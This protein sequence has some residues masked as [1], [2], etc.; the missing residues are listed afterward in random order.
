MISHC[1]GPFKAVGSLHS[2]LNQ[3][4][5]TRQDHQQDLQGSWRGNE[6]MSIP[7]TDGFTSRLINFLILLGWVVTT[8][9]HWAMR[10]RH[11]KSPSLV[12]CLLRL[13]GCIWY[14][15]LKSSIGLKHDFN[16]LQLAEWSYNSCTCLG[17]K[18]K[19]YPQKTT[20]LGKLDRN[21]QWHPTILF[22]RAPT[23][24]SRT[25]RSTILFGLHLFC[26]TERI[27]TAEMGTAFAVH[28]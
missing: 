14:V 7:Q 23:S 12:E 11:Q 22:I 19:W 28:I 27:F 6:A 2:I 16:Y 20:G 3:D 18:P 4:P 26:G 25:S 24:S 17:C 10:K 9:S 5:N 8:S 13:F 15:L 1:N 21:D